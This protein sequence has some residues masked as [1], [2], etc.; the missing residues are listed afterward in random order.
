MILIAGDCELII[1]IPI[2]DFATAYKVIARRG[3]EKIFEFSIN[4]R[5]IMA[6]YRSGDHHP[7]LVKNMIYE[8]FKA[9]WAGYQMAQSMKGKK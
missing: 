5:E 1:N 8:E 9:I 4:Q 6:R 3:G 2:D 7:N